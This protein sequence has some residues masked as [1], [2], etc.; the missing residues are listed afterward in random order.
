MS[1]LLKQ[2]LVDE[3]KNDIKDADSAVLLTYS[4]VESEDNT[5]LRADLRSKKVQMRLVKNSLARISFQGGALESLA[6]EFKGPSAIAYPMEAG[7]SVAVP[8]A[9][10][11]WEEKLKGVEFL[12]GIVDGKKIG[13][14]DILRLANLPGRDELLGQI[15]GLLQSPLVGI[16]SCLQSPLQGIIGLLDALHEK[17]G[18]QES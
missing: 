1:K 16:V 7:D 5:Q 6:D 8:K 12:S 11:D 14:D 15:V 4:G 13:R 10:K 18:A 3:L 9:L 2:L 17:K